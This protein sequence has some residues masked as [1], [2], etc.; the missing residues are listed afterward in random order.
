[1]RTYK[2]ARGL[3]LIELM[4]ATT[5]SLILLSGVV[6]IM[7]SSKR[8]YNT[9]ND[10][11]RLQEN[12]RYAT[13]FITAELRMAGYMGCSGDPL[14]PGELPTGTTLDFMVV[15]RDN[16][17]AANNYSDALQIAFLDTKPGAFGIVHECQE[18]VPS[19]DPDKKEKPCPNPDP[20]SDD[21]AYDPDN[22]THHVPISPLDIGLGRTASDALR[23]I[24][25]I[26]GYYD[27]DLDVGD[28]VVAGDCNGNDP[29]EVRQVSDGI[30][31]RY[32][33]ASGTT[34]AMTG[35][36]TGLVRTY[37]NPKTKGTPTR[38]EGAHLRRLIIHRYFVAPSQT[39]ADDGRFSLYRDID[40]AIDI[41]SDIDTT[42]PPDRL[43]ELVQGVENMQLRYLVSS[44]GTFQYVPASAVPTWDV[45]MGVR[46]TL[47]MQTTK[48]R[49][50]A[51]PDLRSYQLDNEPVA[52]EPRDYRRRHQYTTMVMV[53]N[54]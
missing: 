44:G 12:A 24:P 5:I 54:N 15:G 30:L 17:G 32:I 6:S 14:L 19:P 16:T 40:P 41:T 36:P 3:T 37:N 45:V 27:G 21:P 18:G 52:Y 33:P 48:Q 9:Q 11:A 8:T 1:M 26:T 23:P 49:S 31:L 25:G 53:R 2:H 47:L 38:E 35:V 4:V 7:V 22:P 43:Q 39:G 46:I 29:Y 51:D 34:E 10:L 13:E 28:I 42:L 50:D 20:E